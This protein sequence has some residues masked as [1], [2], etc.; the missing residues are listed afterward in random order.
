M[1]SNEERSPENH[2]LIEVKFKT[3][4]ARSFGFK[5]EEKELA[6][7]IMQG[8]DTTFGVTDLNHHESS[9]F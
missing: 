8:L 4:N 2:Y 3:G 1:N 9:Y 7:S 5:K 6:H